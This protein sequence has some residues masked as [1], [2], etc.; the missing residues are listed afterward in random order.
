MHQLNLSNVFFSFLCVVFF[1]VGFSVSAQ[2]VADD[3]KVN[4][5][6]GVVVMAN[7]TRVKNLKLRLERG[8]WRSKVI[9]ETISDSDGQFTFGQLPPG[10]YQLIV[11]KAENLANLTARLIVSRQKQR[12]V[13]LGVK[14]I[15]GFVIGD[16]SDAST[17]KLN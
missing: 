11:E 6:S 5:V 7:Q 4:S 1:A 15:M 17:M 8:W 14:V 9:A 3:L 2:C 10:K 13:R 12:S 16:C